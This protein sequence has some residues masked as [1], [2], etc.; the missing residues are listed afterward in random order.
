MLYSPP[1]IGGCL[2]QCKTSPD[3]ES[4]QCRR[5]A[6]GAAWDESGGILPRP[7][8]IHARGLELYTCFLLLCCLGPFAFEFAW[9]LL[10]WSRV[11]SRTIG[12]NLYYKEF[13][14]SLTDPTSKVNINALFSLVWGLESWLPRSIRSRGTSRPSIVLTESHESPPKVHLI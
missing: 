14:M 3:C 5:A 4:V 13:T 6:Q 8:S 1:R 9:C 10:L 11:S 7:D 12:M 2:R